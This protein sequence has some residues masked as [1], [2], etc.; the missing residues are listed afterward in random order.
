ML[1]D[2]LIFWLCA[3]IEEL[4]ALI[5]SLDEEMSKP[6]IATDVS[7]LTRISGE[8]ELAKEEL[9]AL[10]EQWETLSE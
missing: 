10:Y 8:Q 3:R 2:N 9:E 7:K 1:G 5:A 6:D 4:E